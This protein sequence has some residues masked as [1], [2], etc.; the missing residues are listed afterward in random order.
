[1]PR[2][3]VIAARFGALL[4]LAL[5]LTGQVAFAQ[6][7]V[8][9]AGM[10]SPRGS[11]VF[12]PS[13]MLGNPGD[14]ILRPGTA[15][16]PVVPAGQVAL[17]LT[18]RFGKDLGAIGGGLDWRV[19][20]AKAEPG[21]R[22]KLVKEDKTASPTLV[23]PAGNYI[24][25]VDFGLA[26]AV[27]PVSL[28]GPAVREQFDLP[29]GGLRIEGRVGNARVP[30]NQISFD[31]YKGSQFEPGDRRPIAEHI[32]TGAVIVVPEGT[33][34]IVSNYGDAN[35]TVRS[36]IR[37]QAGKL[38]DVTVNHRAA[39]ITLKLV[40]EKGGEALANT[41]WSVLTPGGDVIKESIGAFPR[42]ILAEGEYRA[43]ARNEGKV[44]ERGF[45]VVPGVD[46]DVEVLAR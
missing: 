2:F 15:V 19:Y 5:T 30:P 37:V 36:D 31:V 21:G 43:I 13:S 7:S 40:A 33:Y 32:Q 41:A 27:K 14:S 8:P 35:A 38:T 12:G 26:T 10:I 24:V 29:A 17:S 28:R 42:V 9:P 4:A 46:G 18:A 16:M 34:Y 11:D 1:M 45:K 3:P 39:A 22:Y 25:H 23:L 44:Y 20:A 6:S